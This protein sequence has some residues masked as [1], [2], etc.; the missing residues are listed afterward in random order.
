MSRAASLLLLAASLVLVRTQ[1][2]TWPFALP[3]DQG[4][5]AA[6]SDLVE[7][8]ITGNGEC[9]HCLTRLGGSMT[10]LEI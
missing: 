5:P 3:E 10:P 2:T 4:C 7:H 1:N 6:P 8:F 9:P